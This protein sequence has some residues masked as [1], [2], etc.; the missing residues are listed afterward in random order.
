MK[1]FIR[2][3]NKRSAQIQ[4]R[5]EPFSYE[6]RVCA[7]CFY[8]GN[9]PIILNHKDFT[10]FSVLDKFTGSNPEHDKKVH[11]F[12]KIAEA[13]EKSSFNVKKAAALLKI[14]D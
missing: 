2:K 14:E 5:G 9:I 7:S 10:K 6:F 8:D 1:D 12:N 13:I 11:E 4:N 3:E